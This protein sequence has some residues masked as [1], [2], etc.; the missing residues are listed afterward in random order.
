MKDEINLFPRTKLLEWYHSVKRDLP[1]RESKN[2]YS[3]WL[4]EIILQQTRVDQ[5]L[6]YYERFVTAFPTV[7]ALASASED[8]VLKLWEGLGYY[9][10]ARNLHYTAKHITSNL[11]RKFPDSYDGLLSLKGVGPYTA[12]AIGSISF[13]LPNA[14]VDGNVFRVLSRYYGILESIDETATK[15][16]ITKM[17]NDVLPK[18]NSGDHN[19]AMMELGAIICTP[20]KPR[21][22]VCPLAIGCSAFSNQNQNELPV[23]SKKTK[24]RERFFYYMV[25]LSDAGVPI[26]RR[27]SG[28]IWH[29]LYE[30]PLLETARRLD[31]TEMLSELN[32]RNDDV[33]M[34][35]SNEYKHILSHQRIFAKFILVKSNSFELANFVSVEVEKL[36]DFAFPRLINRY[37]DQ[38]NLVIYGEV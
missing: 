24:V 22:E 12:A 16:A 1:W 2:A 37:L 10:R 35:V 8:E 4:S 31:E 6:P 21:C 38:Q 20:T 29:G 28:D 19:Q 9:S 36:K 34:E 33:V 7:E 27:G 3:V 11:G 30:F 32:L 17:A 25:V 26:T 18:E 14:A 23:R 15:N 5:G 13:G